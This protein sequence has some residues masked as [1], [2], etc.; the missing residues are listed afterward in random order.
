MVNVGHS[1]IAIGA[2]MSVRVHRE[3]LKE[4]TQLLASAFVNCET[5]K[6][7]ERPTIFAEP[8]GCGGAPGRLPSDWASELVGIQILVG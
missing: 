4:T 2:N 6:A 1:E 3:T 8:P 5:L 7:L